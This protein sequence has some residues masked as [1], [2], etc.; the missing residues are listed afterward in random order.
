MGWGW[1]VGGR[2]MREGIYVYL[3]RI[4]IVV[5]QKPMQHCK[6]IILQ[7]KINF[8]KPTLTWQLY[9]L[10]LPHTIKLM[11]K[12]EYKKNFFNHLN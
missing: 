9:Q 4:H 10:F 7:F 8:T 5:Y 12:I 3:Y 11:E 1:G 6:A 2:L